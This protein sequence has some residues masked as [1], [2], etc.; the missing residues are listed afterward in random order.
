MA[1]LATR[2]SCRRWGGHLFAFSDER[3]A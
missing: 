1:E 2:P 3:V